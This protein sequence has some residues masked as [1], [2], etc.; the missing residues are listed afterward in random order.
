[1]FDNSIPQGSPLVKY[2]PPAIPTLNIPAPQ[3]E[4]PVLRPAAPSAGALTS[5]L[6]APP[7]AKAKSPNVWD[8]E[9]ISQTLLAIGSGLLSGQNFGE[10]L[11][12]AAQGILGLQQRLRDDRKKS[13]S[14]GGPDDQFEIAADA[15]GNRT[16]RKV[17]EFAEAVEAKRKAAKAPGPKDNLDFR[18]RIVYA[19]RQLPEKDRA[20]AYADVI[21]NPDQYGVDVT[22]MPTAWSDNYGTIAGTMGMT[23]NQG[24][25][26]DRANA[27]AADQIKNREANRGFTERRLT[28]GEERLRQGNERLRR[29]PPSTR[30][31]N[32]D[33]DYLK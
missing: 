25:A 26:Q 8:K 15:Y 2:R 7:P 5:Q 17:P 1:M 4:L 30:K 32:S 23:V 12:N 31:S 10:G 6:P 13:I 27:V 21:A 22:G 19:I 24:I 20:A 16:I 9:H 29:S 33:L 18:G 11:G 14:Y 28:Q 3:A